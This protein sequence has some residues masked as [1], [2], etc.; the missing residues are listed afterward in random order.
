MIVIDTC[1]LIDHSKEKIV[2]E[3]NQ[4]K[5]YYVNSIIQLE[6][7]AGALNKRELKKLNKILAKCQQLELDQDIMNLSVQL[8]NQ[9]GLSN[10]MGIYDS[11]IASTC[12]IYDLPLWTHNK[13]DFR[14][15]DIELL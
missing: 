6:F 3:D 7:L 9:Y 10:G 12:M 5:D 8:I 4:F 2:I 15:L 11:I 1:I 13:K 14:F